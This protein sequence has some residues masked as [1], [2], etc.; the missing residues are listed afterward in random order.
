[1]GFETEL[2][3]T[4]QDSI[5]YDSDEIVWFRMHLDQRGGTT[6]LLSG[7]HA[8]FVR[9]PHP[10]ATHLRCTAHLEADISAVFPYLNTALQG[11]QYFPET[12]SLTLRYH[13][14]LITL[15]SREI[16]INIVKDAEEAGEILEWLRGAI[17][18]TWE[19][20]EQIEPSFGS[21]QRMDLIGVLKLLPRTNCG[22]CGAPTCMVFAQQVAEGKRD[23]AECP[24]MAPEQGDAGRNS[25]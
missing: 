3:I 12:P 16:L 10:Q 5:Q 13:D 18:D 25:S 1:M 19:K 4:S 14:R 24:E 23:L 15:Y 21:K 22:Q 20:R 17:N 7:Y 2:G 9:P 6:M 8:E 11:H